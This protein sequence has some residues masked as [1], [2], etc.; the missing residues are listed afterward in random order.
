MINRVES[1]HALLKRYITSS[2]GD[3]L[4]VWLQIE[5]AVSNQIL[6]IKAEATQERIRTPLNIDQAQY[7]TCFGYITTTALRLAHSNFL[8]TARPLKPCT[9][10]FKATTGLPCVHRIDDLRYA[11]ES[12]YPSDFHGHWH[13]DRYSSLAEPVLEPLRII[14]YSASTSGRT[15]STRRIPS[16][17]KASETQERRYRLCNQPGHTRASMRCTVNIRRLQAEFTPHEP[18]VRESTSE[19]IPRAT[20]QAIL[21]SAN[22]STGQSALRLALQSVLDIGN[23]QFIPKETIQRILESHPAL[24]PELTPELI[25]ELTPDTRPIWP[26]R[27]ELIYKQYLVEK[28]A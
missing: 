13:W 3:L 26:G 24:P 17:F 14:S 1:S 27:I 10:V 5:Q 11:R 15:H 12:L 2:Q 20:V 18:P 19:V 16:G 8:S 6:N 23:P 22:R 7:H 25:R 28:E 9:G 4:T 21:D